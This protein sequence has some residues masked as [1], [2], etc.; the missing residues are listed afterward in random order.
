MCEY[1]DFCAFAHSDEEISIDLIDRLDK[2]FDFYMF[3]FKTV[4]CPYNE[5]THE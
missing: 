3:H 5:G 2:D 1:G 4:W